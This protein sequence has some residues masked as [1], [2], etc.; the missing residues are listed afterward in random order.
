MAGNQV[1]TIIEADG[2]TLTDLE[3]LGLGRQAAAA[4]KSVT[5]AT[6]DKAVSDAIAASLAVLDDWDET[7]RA[8]VNLIVGQAGISA[9]AG[10]VGANTPRMTHASDDPMLAAIIGTV[11]H[12]DADAGN[13]SKIGFKAI[14][15]PKSLTLVPANARTNAYADLDGAM[16]VKLNTTNADIISEAVTDTTGNPTAFTNFG[17]VAGLRN[18][19]T[20][21]NCFRTDAGSTMAYVDF[22]DGVGGTVLWRMPLPEKGGSMET[23]ALPL[24]KSTVNTALAFDVSTPL[25]S[26]FISLSGFQSKA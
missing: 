17:A 14:A 13:A 4:S 7:D 26:V 22:R 6:E 10:A 19:V 12:G 25:T 20:S 16:L 15:S 21:I 5:E 9:G 24:F 3:V 23:S 18:Y 11:A 8:K 1:V 2:S